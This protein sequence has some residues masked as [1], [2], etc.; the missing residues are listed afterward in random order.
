MLLPSIR[1]LALLASMLLVSCSYKVEKQG[2][3]TAIKPSSELV[4]RMSFAEVYT[5]VLQPKCIS[6][7]GTQGGVNLEN[8]ASALSVLEGIRKSTLVERR[9]PKAPTPA[10][11]KDELE[12]LAAWVEAGGPELPRNGG[13]GTTPLPVLEANFA[14]IKANVLVPKCISCH[15]PGGEAARV[16]MVTLD[17]L[18]N[19]PLEIVIPGNPEESGLIL[20]VLPGARKIMP[21]V[22]SGMSALK[23]EEIKVLEEWIRNGA[24]N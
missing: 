7:H 14:S 4:A 12:I 9:M 3:A 15:G 6:C 23:P 18:L 8:H 11:D 24:S 2:D 13:P 21:P 16:P 5:R 17:D 20:S 22:S 1:L 10:L 19:S